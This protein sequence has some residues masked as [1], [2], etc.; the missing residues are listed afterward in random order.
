M[1]KRN[2]AFAITFLS[3]IASKFSADCGFVNLDKVS[4]IRLIM[5]C[6]QK[7]VNL[8]SLSMGKLLVGSHRCSFDVVV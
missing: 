8:V 3:T 7:C 2:V 6:F 1:I 4:N 5:S